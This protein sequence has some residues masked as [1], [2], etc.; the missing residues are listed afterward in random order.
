[1]LLACLGVAAGGL[2]GASLLEA[3][4]KG[5]PL[6]VPGQSIGE[7]R[8]EMGLTEVT[9]KLGEA[10]TG[11]GAAGRAWDAWFARKEGGGRGYELTIYS[12]AA[13]RDKE[14][15][16]IRAESPFFH[17]KENVGTKS[18]LADVWKAFPEL[19]YANN[20]PH[21]KAVEVYMDDA[22]G[23]AIEVRRTQTSADAES[24]PGAWGVCQAIIVFPPNTFPDGGSPQIRSMRDMPDE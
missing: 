24:P 2:F 14:V 5:S 12:H 20:D 22:N 17:T 3:Q 15:R 9:K 16:A 21:D 23:L 4:E 6:I 1:M 11:E 13:E 19:R 18:S 10:A 7:I 8:L